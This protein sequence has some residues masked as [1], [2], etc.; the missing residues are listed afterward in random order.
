MYNLIFS[1]TAHSNNCYLTMFYIYYYTS[2]F[3]YIIN[4]FLY[5]FNLLI[6]RIRLYKN[7]TI[8]IM[9]DLFLKNIQNHT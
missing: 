1:S 5:I 4:K 2:I 9:I 6:I 8:P 3:K 7:Y